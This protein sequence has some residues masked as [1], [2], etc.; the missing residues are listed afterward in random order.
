MEFRQ[1]RQGY[2]DFN[3]HFF[4]FHLSIALFPSSS[5]HS[6]SSP[7]SCKNFSFSPIEISSLIS[8]NWHSALGECWL[9][10]ILLDNSC[11]II[12]LFSLTLRRIFFL[13]FFYLNWRLAQFLL[14]LHRLFSF[15][16]HYT[17]LIKFVVGLWAM[18][19]IKIGK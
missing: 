13:L 10:K 4:F 12:A 1:Q 7:H 9:E 18:R 11:Y 14:H 3:F 6:S 2:Y 5:F 16:S 17:N 15:L 19:W 8:L